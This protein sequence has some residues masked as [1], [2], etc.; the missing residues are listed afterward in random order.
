MIGAILYVFRC[1]EN[2]LSIYNAVQANFHL[3]L[4]MGEGE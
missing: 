2:Y 4:D 3:I 1:Y